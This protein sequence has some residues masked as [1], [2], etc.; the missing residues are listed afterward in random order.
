LHNGILYLNTSETRT[1]T[2]I[3]TLPIHQAIEFNL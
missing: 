1:N 2:F 3:L